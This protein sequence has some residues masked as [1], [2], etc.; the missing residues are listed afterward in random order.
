MERTDRDVSDSP[1]YA[2]YTY[3]DM[4]TTSMTT[5]AK[6]AGRG[7]QRQGGVELEKQTMLYL[8]RILRECWLLCFLEN[9]TLI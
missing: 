8:L 6:K 9:W 5:S 1:A 3:T 4:M 2:K 7:F